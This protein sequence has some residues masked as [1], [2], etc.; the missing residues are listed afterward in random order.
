[1][2]MEMAVTY[3]NYSICVNL[4]I[5]IATLV[6]RFIIMFIKKLQKHHKNRGFQKLSAEP[7]IETVAVID[8]I[9]AYL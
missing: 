8:A 4:T 9:F 2:L 3:L 7:W 5:L 1:M 6:W